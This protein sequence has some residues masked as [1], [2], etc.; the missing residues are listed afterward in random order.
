LDAKSLESIK[1]I[2]KLKEKHF[3]ASVLAAFTNLVEDKNQNFVNIVVAI[4]ENRLQF[5]QTEPIG[6]KVPGI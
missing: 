1:G 6:R 3:F 5:F 2:Y 4:L